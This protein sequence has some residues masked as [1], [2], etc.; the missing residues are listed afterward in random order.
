MKNELISMQIRVFTSGTSVGNKYSLKPTLNTWSTTAWTTHDYAIYAAGQCTVFL[1]LLLPELTLGQMGCALS[2]FLRTTTIS[3]TELL[4]SS[5]SNAD[6]N[7]PQL[8]QKVHVPA[9]A[10]SQHGQLRRSIL[11][12]LGRYCGFQGGCFAL[13]LR[14]PPLTSLQDYIYGVMTHVNT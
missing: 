9:V 5:R 3:S 13:C 1:D 10:R 6:F 14:R 8:W 12:E 11:H 2:W 4:S 7:D